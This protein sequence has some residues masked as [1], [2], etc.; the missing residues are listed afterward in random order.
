MVIQH[1][2]VDVSSV[3]KP[4]S[5]RPANPQQLMSVLPVVMGIIWMEASVRHVL[6]VIVPNA[7]QVHQSARSTRQT[8]VNSPSK[9]HKE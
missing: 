3:I 1:L 7:Q 9:Q 2:A 6:K 8:Q 4:L 5:V